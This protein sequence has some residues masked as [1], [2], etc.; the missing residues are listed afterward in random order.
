M[1][2]GGYFFFS[3]DELLD[4]GLYSGELTEIVGAAGAGKSQVNLKTCNLIPTVWPFK[5]NN[6]IN[7][8]A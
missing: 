1:N 7:V 4:G 5:N 8:I 6:V 3:L 2:L